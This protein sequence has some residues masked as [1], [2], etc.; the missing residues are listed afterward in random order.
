MIALWVA[1]VYLFIAGKHYFVAMIPAVFMTMATTTYILNAQIGFR[2][3]L[4]TSY[5]IA[6]VVTAVII[7]LFYKRAIRAKKD[8]IPLEE[9]ISGRPAA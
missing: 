4:E 6:A 8:N 3:P 2:L 7:G 5:Y 9:D 1:A